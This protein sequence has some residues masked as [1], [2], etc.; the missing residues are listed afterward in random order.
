L[1][2]LRTEFRQPL[3]I[4]RREAWEGGYPASHT[5][6]EDPDAMLEQLAVQP[7]AMILD[8]RKV[9][10]AFVRSRRSVAVVIGEIHSSHPIRF[11]PMC[12]AR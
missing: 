5:Q 6:I 10:D 2:V 12:A 4:G 8:L 1:I 11:A 3:E 7:P 9:P